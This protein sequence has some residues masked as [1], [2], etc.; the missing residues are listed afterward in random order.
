MSTRSSAAFWE[1]HLY[2]ELLNGRAYLDVQEF[3]PKVGEPHH[4]HV[5]RVRV[6]VFVWRYFRG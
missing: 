1:V 5:F 2:L 3:E 6:P 4:R